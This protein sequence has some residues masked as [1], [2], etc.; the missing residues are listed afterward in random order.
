MQTP[1]FADC[2]DFT[3]AQEKAI[4]CWNAREVISRNSEFEDI[5]ALV[6]E[7]DFKVYA[8][9]FYT[10]FSIIFLQKYVYIKIYPV[11]LL[12]RLEII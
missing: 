10:N 11:I 9:R 5:D 1:R 7:Q 4:S 6:T 8:E 3:T 2:K 12:N